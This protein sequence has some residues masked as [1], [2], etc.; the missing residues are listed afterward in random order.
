MSERSKQD[1]FWLLGYR[2]L[3]S[4]IEMGNKTEL[5]SLAELRRSRSES[6]VAKTTGVYREDYCKEGT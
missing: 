5:G 6:G 4:S 1:E 2:R 3:P